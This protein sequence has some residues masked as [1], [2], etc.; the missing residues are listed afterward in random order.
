MDQRV[1]LCLQGKA[2]QLLVRRNRHHNFIA[3]SVGTAIELFKILKTLICALG[4][5]AN[6]QSGES[7]GS[8]C[9][10]STWAMGKC[11]C[12]ACAVP[13]KEREVE[14]YGAVVRGGIGCGKKGMQLVG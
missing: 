8:G 7:R 13:M 6:E 14:G 9:A 11:R 3:I 5:T 4:S 2:C 1:I 12:G 10:R